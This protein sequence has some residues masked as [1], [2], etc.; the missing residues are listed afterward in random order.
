MLRNSVLV[1]RLTQDERAAIRRLARSERLPDSTLARQLLLK[2]AEQRGL[3]P[4]GD[5]SQPD[6]ETRDE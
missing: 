5:V 2:A 1:I 3:L 6:Q 4:D